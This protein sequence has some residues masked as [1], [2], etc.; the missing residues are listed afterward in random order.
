MKE[1]IFVTSNKGKVL[2]MQK[3]IDYAGLDVKIIQKTINEIIE[4]QADTSTE[5]ALSKV[6]QAY[7]IIKKPLLVDDSSF[8]ISVLG[9]FPGPYIKYMISTI[10][11]D[12]I[13]SFMKDKADRS[14]YFLSSLVF[15]DESGKEHVFEEEPYYG[16]IAH[17]VDDYES[18]KAWGDLHKIFIPA[19]TDKV[20]IR[21]TDEERLEIDK[22]KSDVY[23]DFCL[24]IKNGNK[25]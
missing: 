3:N 11:V 5:V 14:A 7:K 9:G 25:L 8:H 22:D 1:I 13:L 18:E 6:R 16:V 17:E 4:P 12:G 10:G 15:I 2:T 19:G 20:L 21:L 23:K 24:W